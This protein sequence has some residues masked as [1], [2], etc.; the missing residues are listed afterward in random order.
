MFLLMTFLPAFADTNQKVEVDVI[1]LKSITVTES[2]AGELELNLITDKPFMTSPILFEKNKNVYFVSLPATT[3]SGARDVDVSNFPGNVKSITVDFI[4]YKSRNGEGYTRVIINSP[5]KPVVKEA[6]AGFKF[7]V[8]IVMLSVGGLL[9]LVLLVYLTFILYVK[10]KDRKAKPKIELDDYSAVEQIKEK[11]DA[12]EFLDDGTSQSIELLDDDIPQ[13]QES[14]EYDELLDKL[15][16]DDIA[17]DNPKEQEIVQE[18]AEEHVYNEATV[19]DE[20]VVSQ[21]QDDVWDDNEE[22]F[23]MQE[24]EI[25]QEN[26]EEQTTDEAVMSDEQDSVKSELPIEP[27]EI[28]EDILSDD[29]VLDEISETIASDNHELL[30]DI[31]SEAYSDDT[32]LENKNETY[33]EATSDTIADTVEQL[34]YTVEANEDLAEDIFSENSD[35]EQIQH[36]DEL[37]EILPDMDAP[38]DDNFIQ[39]ESI[40]DEILDEEEKNLEKEAIEAEPIFDDI[41]S[42]NYEAQAEPDAEAENELTAENEPEVQA[43]N[44]QQQ[45]KDYTVTEIHRI[46]AGATGFSNQTFDLTSKVQAKTEEQD[47]DASDEIVSPFETFG[48]E[49]M[50]SGVIEPEVMQNDDEQEITITD[51]ESEPVIEI[52]EEQAEELQVS[53]TDV[54]E[55]NLNIETESVVDVEEEQPVE[56]QITELTDVY[57]ENKDQTAIIQTDEQSV[58][59]A[60]KDVSLADEKGDTETISMAEEQEETKEQEIPRLSEEIEFVKPVFTRP[61]FD[62]D[63][64]FVDKKVDD[65]EDE[66]MDDIPE[67]VDDF[68]AEKDEYV[69]PPETEPETDWESTY[70]TEPK[71]VVVD[72]SEP[73]VLDKK[74]FSK[75]KT[76]YLLRHNGEFSL[77]AT[78]N[79]NV[80][81]IERFDDAPQKQEII[82]KH[83]EKRA[84]DD[85]YIAK[86]GTWR[87]LLSV[88]KDSVKNILTL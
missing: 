16:D 53:E 65:E 44:V 40:L 39:N 84:K 29:N 73:I 21:N 34:A 17:G 49:G 76:L 31:E 28:V 30:N 50:M 60:V 37:D 35:I 80:F 78:I 88:S 75:T 82:L 87:A 79:D 7:P 45:P 51:E 36:V 19:L 63:T 67:N 62:T 68:F 38:D 6:V 12:L 52:E 83:N 2:K 8:K 10:F 4:P 74:A 59:E 46:S 22:Q 71:E 25:V 32:T 54:T 86:V 64:F 9:T 56:Q 85:V 41:M 58:V 48:F 23:T 72:D 81:V 42:D 24:Q 47:A 61:A 57:E 69:S 26:S 55:E 33:S 13:N 14:E 3:Y 27:N 18:N 77:V 11:S 70:K 66:E 43:Q 20:Q 1:E 5:V 15:Y